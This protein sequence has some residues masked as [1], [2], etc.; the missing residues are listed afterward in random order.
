MSCEICW[1][2]SLACLCAGI[3]CLGTP[4]QK[5]TF[6]LLHTIFTH[7]LLSIL[8]FPWLSLFERLFPHVLWVGFSRARV[9][10]RLP[11]DFHFFAFTTFTRIL[12]QTRKIGLL[13]SCETSA[14]NL[15]IAPLFKERLVDLLKYVRK[16]LVKTWY[17]ERYAEICEGCESKKV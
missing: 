13:L 14:G 6:A 10:A 8:F 4:S 1:A 15:E 7:F 3:L 17:K 16:V 12:F 2:A 9:H 5:G 11:C